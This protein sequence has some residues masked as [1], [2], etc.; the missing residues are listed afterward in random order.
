MY[1]D[2]CLKLDVDEV[3]SLKGNKFRFKSSVLKGSI[4]TIKGNG[5]CIDNTFIRIEK[6]KNKFGE[7]HLFLCP[8][9][10]SPRKHM[11][12]V[13]GNWKCRECGSLRY[14]TT[15]TYRRG[16]EYCDLKIDKILDK[17]KLEHDIKYY[18][19]LLP[20]SNLKPKGMRWTTYNKLIRSLIY[21]Q[22]ERE[23]RWINLAYKYIN[24]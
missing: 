14:R 5:I 20:K 16:M 18:T 23:N 6:Y 12:L 11:Y 10:L 3:L 17:L 19:G 21:W 1:V 15:N 7:K 9:C 13:K 8:Y 24:K 2:E 22:N 4:L